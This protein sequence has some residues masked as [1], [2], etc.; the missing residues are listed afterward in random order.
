MGPKGE[1]PQGGNRVQKKG[2]VG[3]GRDRAKRRRALSGKPSNR[4]YSAAPKDGGERRKL[5]ILHIDVSAYRLSLVGDHQRC[6]PA[7]ES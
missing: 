7:K 4:A 2:L 3:G 5:D 6:K 1:Q